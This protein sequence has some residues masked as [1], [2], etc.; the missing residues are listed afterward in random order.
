MTQR[1]ALCRKEDDGNGSTEEEIVGQYVGWYQRDGTI[2]GGSVCIT[3][4]LH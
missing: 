3:N 4:E 1:A 2:R